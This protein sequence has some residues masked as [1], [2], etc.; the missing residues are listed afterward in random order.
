M[1]EKT[2]IVMENSRRLGLN[3]HRGKSKILKINSASTAPILLEDVALEE[4]ESFTY[5]GSIVDKK[6]GTD[7]DVRVWIGKARAAFKQL[8]NV[9]KASKLT[10]TQSLDC[11]TQQSSQRSAVWGRNLEDY[12]FNNEPA[13]DVH[14]RVPQDNFKDQVARKDQQPRAVPANE[15]NAS[16]VRDPLEAMGMG[17][18]HTEETRLQHHEAGPYLELIRKEEAGKT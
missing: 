8:K 17:W 5:L 1:Q 6:G 16:R 18:A 10:K 9:W 14:Q 7:A 12:P 11:S 2:N 4:V 13:T 3:I 15:A